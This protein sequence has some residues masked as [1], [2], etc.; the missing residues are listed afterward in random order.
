MPFVASLGVFL[1]AALWLAAVPFVAHAQQV[2]RVEFATERG[3]KVSALFAT[4]S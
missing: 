2:V 3:E 1:A 4:P